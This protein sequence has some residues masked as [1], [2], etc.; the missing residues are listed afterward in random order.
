LRQIGD[1]QLRHLA[2][3]AATEN[4]DFSDFTIG[5]VSR[6]CGGMSLRRNSSTSQQHG[7]GKSER[8]FVNSKTVHVHPQE[9]TGKLRA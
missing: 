7:D 8:V 1:S 5:G 4:D 9:S 2:R 6:S 3:F